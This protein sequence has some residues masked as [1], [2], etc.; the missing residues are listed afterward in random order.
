[1]QPLSPVVNTGANFRQA[2]AASEHESANGGGAVD[3]LI[4]QDAL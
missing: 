1:M 2:V 4:D 3:D